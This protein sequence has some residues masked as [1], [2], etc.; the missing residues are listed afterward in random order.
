MTNFLKEQMQKYKVIIITSQRA[1]ECLQQCIES[2]DIE[3]HLRDQIL[4]IP[5]Y[6][7]GPSTH[8]YLTNIGFRNIIGKESGNGHKLSNLILNEVKDEPIIYFTG[9]IRKDIIPNNMI[10]N[11][12]NFSEFPVY[13]TRECADVDAIQGLR[14][15]S[16]WVI[17]FSSQGTQNIVNHIKNKNYKVGVIGPTTNEYLIQNGITADLVCEAPTADSLLRQ[18]DQYEKN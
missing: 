5:V 16:S 11:G 10:N 15:E 9:E 8:E 12:K 6:T 1:V 7:I 17:F 3:E 2:K 18:I 4:D 13:A 14:E